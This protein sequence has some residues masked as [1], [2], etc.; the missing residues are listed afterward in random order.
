MDGAPGARSDEQLMIDFSHGSADAF[1]ELFLRYKQ[2]LF[3]FFR[4]RVA[5][6]G[7]AEE[8]T[9]DTFVAVVRASGR[10]M[11]SATFRTWLYAIGYTILRAD[12]R[13]R[14]FRGMFLREDAEVRDRGKDN[15]I[16]IDLFMR[17]ALGKLDRDE[18][19]ILL[20]RE[21]EQLSYA[22]I[23]ELLRLPVNTVR[24]RLFRARMALRELLTAPSTKS[25]GN[26]F[27]TTE[28]EE[29]V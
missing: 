18:R 6:V 11:P 14:A 20:L 27:A 23:A 25:S 13:K 29:G 16:D 10:Y 2:Q 3:G 24:S 19:E 17:D 1:E 5:D 7:R 8:L 22:E 12:R 28:F 21:F 9:Q 4:R 26:D 15:T